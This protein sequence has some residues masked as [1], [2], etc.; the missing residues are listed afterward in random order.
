V[1]GS[2]GGC[3]YKSELSD[4]ALRAEFENKWTVYILAVKV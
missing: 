3:G 2:V 1:S 4:S